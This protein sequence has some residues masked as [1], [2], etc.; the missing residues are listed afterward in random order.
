MAMKRSL[1]LLCF[2]C[3]AAICFGQTHLLSYD[4]LKYLLTNNLQKADTFM[5]A[6]GYL[7][8]SKNND[9]KNRS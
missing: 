3:S 2:T 7:V 8:T 4:D 1:L 5:M 6:K 9:T